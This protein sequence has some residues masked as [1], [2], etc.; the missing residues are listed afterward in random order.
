MKRIILTSFALLMACAISFAEPVQNTVESSTAVMCSKTPKKA[1]KDKKVKGAEATETVA[2]KPEK[3]VGKYGKD[4]AECIKYLSYYS[5]YFKQ[6]SYD[7]ALPSWRKAF[8]ICPPTA[9][10]TMLQNGATLYKRLIEKSNVDFVRDPLIDTLMTI[11]DLRAQYYPKYAV[12][13]LNNKGV[14]MFKYVKNDSKRAY[15]T[16]KAIIEANGAETNPSIFLYEINSAVE[17]Y[18]EGEISSDEIIDCYV[19]S[20]GFLEELVAKDP[21]EKNQNVKTDVENIFITSKCASCDDLVALFQP[22]YEADPENLSLL[23]KI[24]KMMSITEG[25]IETELFLNA[26]EGMN[27]LDPTYTSAYLLFKLY[28]SKGQVNEAIEAI[29]KAIAFP[30][31]NDALD[32][33]YNYELA[34]FAYKNGRS[35]KAFEAAKQAAAL[36]PEYAGKA[37][38][39]CGNLWMGASCGGN[40]VTS[41]AKYWVAADFFAKAKA[42]DASLAAEATSNMGRC[43]AYYPAAADAFMYGYT[44]GQ[45]YTAS[46]SGMTCGTSVRVNK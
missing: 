32:G 37:Y 14:D 24:A 6:K 27:K 46:C 5:E 34:A 36:S 30:E 11:Y 39:I 25:G 35:G 40:E 43:A 13:S 2:A 17:L 3:P 16:Y 45:G 20:S 28:S 18:N 23:T 26:V 29:E 41:R 44:A 19:T 9:N 10:Y 15:E 31:S 33:Q 7:E 38:M 22:R 4:S 1:K 21:S 12:S 42:A 8:A